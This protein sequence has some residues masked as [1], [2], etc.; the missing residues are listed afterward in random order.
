[1]AEA[2]DVTTEDQGSTD[3]EIVETPS[4]MP[5]HSGSITTEAESLLAR[6]RAPRKSGLTRP[7]KIRQN[8]GTRTRKS[9]PS[10]NTDPASISPAK[11]VREFPNEA[12][13]Q[14]AEKKCH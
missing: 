13:V 8:V 5:L 7:E 3:M 9:K 1:M 12:S 14:H 6:L 2:Q 4:T 10:C 11:R